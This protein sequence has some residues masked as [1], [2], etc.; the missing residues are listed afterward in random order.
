MPKADATVMYRSH[1]RQSRASCCVTIPTDTMTMPT[2]EAVMRSDRSSTAAMAREA[3][4]STTHSKNRRG[5]GGAES[6]TSLT[7]AKTR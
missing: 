3:T 2:M 6:C 4:I 1:C 7:R 5:R